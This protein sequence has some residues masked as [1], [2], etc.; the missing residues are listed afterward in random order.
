MEQSMHTVFLSLGSNLGDREANLMGA[1][2]KIKNR[3]G[4][5]REQSDFFVTNPEGFES[6]NLFLN[7]ALKVET[8]LTPDNLL[9]ATQAIERELGREQKSVNGIYHDRPIDIDILLIDDL[10][11]DTPSL[12]VPHPRML[13]RLFVLQPL[14][15][16]AP[17]LTVP[18]T[19]C[20]ISQLL[21]RRQEA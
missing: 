19:N 6:D 13:D 21:A 11:I 15:Q 20:Q 7:A 18:G 16:I 12:T 5:I 14:A 2:D 9:L 17:T 1:I 8:A 10:Q 3:I 4:P